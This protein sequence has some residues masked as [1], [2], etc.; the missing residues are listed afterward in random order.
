MERNGADI[1]AQS[2]VAAGLTHGFHVPGEGILD[3]LDA[4]AHRHPGITLVHCRHE[5]GSAF[6]AIG[7]ARAT[8]EREEVARRVPGHRR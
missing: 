8:G 1:L 6:A 2:L 5:A 3:L 7:H 4:L